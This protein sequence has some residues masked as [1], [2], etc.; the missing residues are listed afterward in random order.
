[1][2]ACWTHSACTKNSRSYSFVH[3]QLERASS[4]EN[5][6]PEGPTY[7]DGRSI[8]LPLSMKKTFQSKNDKLSPNKY[9]PCYSEG[10]RIRIFVRIC[11]CMCARMQVCLWKQMCIY[12]DL[13][14]FIRPRPKK[15]PRPCQGPPQQRKTAVA[16]NMRSPLVICDARIVSR[17]GLLQSH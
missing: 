8:P 2:Y 16:R 9:W 5:F 13:L 3:D 4:I 15:Q 14:Q 6:S 12:M 11:L 17:R 1:M 7:T 10:S